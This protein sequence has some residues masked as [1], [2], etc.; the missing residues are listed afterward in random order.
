VA[1]P[2]ISP[3]VARVSFTQWQTALP[4]GKW[5]AGQGWKK[6]L[7]AVSDF[8][9]G[10]DAEAAFTRGFADAGGQVVGTIRFPSNN[11]DFAPFVQK[12]KDA[13]PDVLF[14]FVPGGTQATAM[15]KAIR[16]LGVRQAGIAVVATQDL[17]ADEELPN[18]GDAPLGLVT[19]GNYSA[20]VM[21]PAN[22]AFVAAWE[23]EY[24]AVS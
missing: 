24:G 17:V 15:M 20:A 11:P 10:H 9:P 5:S 19:A 1:I 18:M 8:I 4:L 22:I 7:T 14:I 23:K 6:A 2:R 3:Y 16:D 13:R 12:A 21:R